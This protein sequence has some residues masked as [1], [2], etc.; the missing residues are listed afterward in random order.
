M[1]TIKNE[2]LLEP[3]LLYKDRLKEAFHNNAVE[4]FDKLT[5]KGQVNVDLNQD[6]CKK[7]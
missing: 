2:E 5:E 3:L 1:E 7:Y 6:L 4:F